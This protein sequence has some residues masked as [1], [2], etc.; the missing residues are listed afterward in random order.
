MTTFKGLFS[1]LTIIVFAVLFAAGCASVTDANINAELPSEPTV[2]TASLD[3]DNWFS[4]GAGETLDPIL[5]DKPDTD[6]E[7]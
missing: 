7:R 5:G 3:G 2:E 4:S 1:K 6:G